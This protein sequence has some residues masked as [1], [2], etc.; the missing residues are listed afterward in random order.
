MYPVL[1]PSLFVTEMPPAPPP[2][3]HEFR[4]GAR[5]RELWSTPPTPVH[6]PAP[7]SATPPA[8]PRLASIDLLRG[9]IMVLMTLDHVRDF[10]AR[11]A[12]A[13]GMNPRDVNATALFLTRWVTHFCAPTFILLAGM[14]A[15]L[16]GQRPGRTTRDVGRFLLT[17]GL[18]LVLLELTLVNF[19]WTFDVRLEFLTLQV[20]WAIGCSMIFLAGLVYLPRAVVAA[21]AVAMICGHNL[22]DGVRAEQLGALSWLWTLL[23]EPGFL[24]PIAGRQ[25]FALYPLIPW[26][27]V[28]AAGYA[29]GPVILLDARRRRAAL[30]NVGIALTV[31]FIVLRG[32]GVY[33]D[34]ADLVVH[35]TAWATFLSLLNCEKYPPS[36][37]YLAMTLGPALIALAALDVA[38]GRVANVFTTIG[39]VPFLYYLAHIYLIHVLAVAAA[40]MT[41]NGDV[42]WLFSGTALLNKPTTFGFSLPVVYLIWL[43][44]VALLYPLCR[45]FAAVKQRRKDWWLSYL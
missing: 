29:L 41:G 34:P 2:W 7:A 6:H 32:T 37:L 45:W 27:G 24:P 16:Y 26:V 43:A 25:L 22:L 39:R 8:R 33:G 31:L 11:A 40:A 19:G 12:G 10:F 38:R 18:W 20:I 30:V 4:R 3:Q 28:M 15:F 42:A 36:L 17:R 21:V 1:I 13:G 9:V 5:P 23:H 35:D 14:S 44:V